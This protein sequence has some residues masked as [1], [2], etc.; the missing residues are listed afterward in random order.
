[1]PHFRQNSFAG[2]EV[3]PSLYGRSDCGKYHIALARCR[4]VIPMRDGSAVSRPGTVYVDAAPSGTCR[5]IPFVY[6]NGDAYVLLFSDALLTV[7]KDGVKQQVGTT[8][9][10]IQE[11]GS[12]PAYTL[13]T[14]Y[15][16]ADLGRL[17][18][19]Q[20]GN[21]LTIC[22]PSYAPQEL[23]RNS[24]TS[25]SIA[26]LSFEAST[27]AAY[28]ESAVPA[29]LPQQR[30]TYSVVSGGGFGPPVPMD[31]WPPD[32]THE[33][34]PWSWGVTA[35]VLKP[36]GSVFETSI[37]PFANLSFFQAPTPNAGLYDPTV[38]YS[39]NDNV[40]ADDLTG[41]YFRSL[42]SGNT[43]HFPSENGTTSSEWW[44]GPHTG[45]T[46]TSSP[47]QTY[48]CIGPDIPIALVWPSSTLVAGFSGWGALGFKILYW[49]VY[50]R[51]VSG[52]GGLG[53]D[54]SIPTANENWG[55]IG[56]A[57]AIGP[58]PQ[59][60]TSG[61]VYSM[62]TRVL[63][64][65]LTTPNANPPNGA[66]A[67]QSP[68][69]WYCNSV[70]NVARPNEE[71]GVYEGDAAR[72]VRCNYWPTNQ[73]FVDTGQ[74]PDYTVTPPTGANPFKVYD[75]S[76]PF[77]DAHVITENPSVVTYFEQRRVFANTI[78]SRTARPG[79]LFG[80]KVGDYINFDKSVVQTA[81][82]EYEFELASQRYEEIRGL[83]PVSRLLTF[84]NGSEWAVGGSGGALAY[85]NVDAKVQGNH[86]SSWLD[87]LNLGN[88]ALFVQERGPHIQA[89]L[90]DFGSQSWDSTELNVF[91]DHLLD[92]HTIVS[93]C[94]AHQPYHAVFMVR[95]D[96]VLLSMTY[97]REQEV[98]GWGWH[99]SSWGTFLDVCTVP[100]AN[101]DAVYF[102]VNRNRGTCLE[103]LASLSPGGTVD[104][105]PELDAAVESTFPTELVTVLSGSASTS[106]V[107]RS[108]AAYSAGDWTVRS[109]YHYLAMTDN[110]NSPTGSSSCPT[111][112]L[113]P[114][115]PA[116]T[117]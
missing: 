14:P 13:V 7:Y 79:W 53:T 12:T 55:W 97:M 78:S 91:A 84:T 100:E 38:T 105:V 50:R 112:T 29:M 103:R 92:G 93:W 34:K 32:A 33:A 107:W 44:S 67:F 89:V 15:A 40:V 37:Q 46:M 74:A 48:I 31:Y 88:E 81:D 76:Y 73:M 71:P 65:T 99:D 111:T 90:F 70:E 51:L 3:S 23:T 108:D 117:S 6:S 26:A 104:D 66:S 16:A 54:K 5:L 116:T 110:A 27:F 114:T 101:E 59:P 63:H 45:A 4:N 56:D 17:K 35:V 47:L 109:G 39:L 85:D 75:P 11:G 25:W 41:V 64:N 19:A 82:Q 83:L 113:P 42:Q 52:I 24:A 68:Q 61:A 2:G 30:P 106:N 36:D 102:L 96:G 87:P 95:D 86:G 58:P 115:R 57:P 18:Y 22:H 80:S 49:R 72:W 21:V 8:A 69:A 94:W 9:H 28:S 60:W 20:L 98:N 62:G 43:G 77:D 1:V 10:P